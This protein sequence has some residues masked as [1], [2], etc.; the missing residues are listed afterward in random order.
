M[1]CPAANAM[2]FH[3]IKERE[4]ITFYQSKIVVTTQC[5]TRINLLELFSNDSFSPQLLGACVSN[6]GKVFHLEVCSRDFVS[7]VKGI[8]QRVSFVIACSDLYQ[9]F[10]HFHYQILSVPHTTSIIPSCVHLL[11]IIIYK[12]PAFFLAYPN[13]QKFKKIYI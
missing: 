11:F 7:E 8:L 10:T 1:Q 13:Y 2:L 12:W 3:S 6:C 9:K 5:K 4:K